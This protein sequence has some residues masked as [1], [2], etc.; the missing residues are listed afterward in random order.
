[1]GPGRTSR[2]WY[3]HSPVYRAPIE[4]SADALADPSLMDAHA[5]LYLLILCREHV[6]DKNYTRAVIYL[7]FVAIS[8]INGSN[9]KL[10]SS[11]HFFS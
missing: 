5:N 7:Q 4:D 3:F 2:A 8:H 11:E 10:M 9:C 1:M 6:R